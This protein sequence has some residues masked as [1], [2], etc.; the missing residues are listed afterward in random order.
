[1]NVFNEAFG[2]PARERPP[3]KNSASI[4]RRGPVREADG[5]LEAGQDSRPIRLNEVPRL[6]SRYSGGSRVNLR[7]VYRYALYGV[8]EVVLETK[9]QG[10]VLWTTPG[11]VRLFAIA[12]AEMRNS[13][14]TSPGW[15]ALKRRLPHAGRPTKRTRRD[16]ESDHEAIVDT[17]SATA[18]DVTPAAGDLVDQEGI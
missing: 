3:T 14:R 18:M 2:E 7:V 13:V 16:H 1:M 9:R 12:L 4:R 6:L 15:V 8:R 17:E 5:G 11:A 10:S